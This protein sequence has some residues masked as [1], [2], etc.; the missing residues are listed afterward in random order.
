MRT[1]LK[2]AR[3]EKGFTVAETAK[4]LNVSPAV[5]Y[6]W[7]DGTRAPLI[8]NARQ[9]A[10]LFEKSIEEL[11]FDSELDETSNEMDPMPTGTEG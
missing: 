4:I 6:K 5:Y 3:I 11:F 7:E 9:V 8:D 2:Q 1:S 10:A